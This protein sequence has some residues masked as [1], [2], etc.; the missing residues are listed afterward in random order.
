[1]PR[2]AGG[3]VQPKPLWRC[4]DALAPRL[5]KGA[6]L[7]GFDFDGTLAPIRPT[8]AEAVADSSTR[9]ALATLASRPGTAVAVV[10]GRPLAQLRALVPAE[11]LWL[12]GLHGL[13]IAAPDGEVLPT[14]DLDSAATALAPLRGQARDIAARHPGTWIEDKGPSLVL[15]TRRAARAEGAAAARELRAAAHGLAGFELLTGKETLEVRPAGTSKGAAICR[16]VREA[17]GETVLYVGDDTTDED[18]FVALA[19]LDGVTVRV[20]RSPATAAAFGLRSQGEVGELLRRL[21]AL[22]G[23]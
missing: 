18:A 11:A 16:L 13:E 9:E 12:V 4:W 19:P 21:V 7:A 1:M 2:A 14:I 3:R 5:A 20:G 8:P 22:R 23:G 6:L 10:S 15:H 17:A